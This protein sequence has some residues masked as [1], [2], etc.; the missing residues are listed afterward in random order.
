MSVCKG[1]REV[2][3]FDCAGG[4]QV[5]VDGKYAYIGH[6]TGPDGTTIADVSDPKHPK[7]VAELK[8]EDVGIHSHKARAANG[9]MLVN[10]EIDPVVKLPALHNLSGKGGLGIFDVSD[11]TKPKLITVW[12]C[13]GTGIHR[14]TFDGR[15]AYISPTM[16]GYKNNIV[17]ILDLKNPAKPE[18]VG[19]WWMP[20]QWMEGGE[21]P[22]W[23]E[24]GSR[25]PRCHHPIRMGDRLYVSYW[26]GGG[27]ILDISDMSKPKWVS[28]I[29]WSPPFPWPT[30]SLVPI[31][32]EIHGHK[33]MLV[34]DED[35]LPKEHDVVFGMPAALWMVNI[36]DEKKPTPV[37][38]YQ[39]PGVDGDPK[40]PQNT[41]CHQPVEDI[42]GNEVP[43]AWFAQGLRILDISNPHNLREVASYM[44]DP[45]PG[46]RR[47]S[48]NDVFQ[49]DR[50]L[51]YLIDRVRGLHIVERI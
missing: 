11:P 33:W 7:K 8:L 42:R 5:M 24:R 1:V 6:I 26:H 12:R 16:K 28:S 17:V 49:D 41:A 34:A 15:Y 2:G 21:K 51:I 25:E 3:F 40:T 35:V 4:G 50:G 48:S 9:I 38:S 47:V 36:T 13:E 29:D 31:P 30:H 39:V 46:A 32:F 23:K 37:G 19:R 43:C 20:G 14:F 27:F 10:Y 22:E 45:A 44:P 18:E